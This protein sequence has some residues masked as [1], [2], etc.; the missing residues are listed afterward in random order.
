MNCSAPHCDTEDTNTST[1][2]A[3]IN[4]V[5]GVDVEPALLYVNVVVPT[6]LHNLPNDL[7]RLLLPCSR[8]SFVALVVSYNNE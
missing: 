1:P 8:D 3:S 7:L 4:S 6:G 5:A 2:A